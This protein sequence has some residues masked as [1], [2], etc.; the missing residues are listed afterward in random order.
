MAHANINV[1][2]KTRR[3]IIRAADPAYKSDQ[4]AK[5]SQMNGCPDG[6]FRSRSEPVRVAQQKQPSRVEACHSHPLRPSPE[7]IWTAVLESR[8]AEA[9]PRA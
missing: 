9:A 4:T 2:V 6:G 3:P 5:G 1:L 7:G 8:T